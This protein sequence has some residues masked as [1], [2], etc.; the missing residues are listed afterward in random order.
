VSES[1]ER[2]LGA[3]EAA[4]IDTSVALVDDSLVTGYLTALGRSLTSRTSRANLD[5]RFT[6][7]NSS[8]V[9]AMALPGGFVYVTRAMIE[10]AGQMD[11]LAG[12]MSHE[13]GHV[14]HRHSVKQLEQAGKREIALLM[15]CTLTH[16]CR[17]LG[18]AIAVQVGADAATAQYSQQ[19]ESE[20]D[21]EAVLITLHAG[22][23]PEGLPTFLRA[24]MAQRTDQPS[25][26]DAFFA[27][28]PTDEARIS[29]LDRQIARLTLK[30][31]QLLRDAP[32]F[33]TIQARLRAMPPPP[34][35]TTGL[36]P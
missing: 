26:I 21:S 29:A 34:R 22:I 9:N 3:Y 13:I 15:L 11:E 31:G 36:V 5:W 25:P 7:V 23:D 17:T 12:V 35:D 32:D 19:D 10:Q 24:V 16:A 33:H 14:V 4:T 30:P 8:A 28:H 6:V 1:E 20:A 2:E 27:S 18:G